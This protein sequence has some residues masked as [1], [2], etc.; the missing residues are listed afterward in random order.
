M[1]QLDEHRVINKTSMRKF[2]VKVAEITLF[3]DKETQVKTCAQAN[4]AANSV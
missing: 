1:Y 4:S 2:G 3:F